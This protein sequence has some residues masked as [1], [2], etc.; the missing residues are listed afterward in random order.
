MQK[1]CILA[2]PVPRAGRYMTKAELIEFNKRTHDELRRS[3]SW[4]HERMGG[5]YQLQCD[6]LG[7]YL[8]T[9]KPARQIK[10]LV[11]EVPAWGRYLTLA[12]TL[13]ARKAGMSCSTGTQVRP[14]AEGGPVLVYKLPDGYNY[15]YRLVAYERRKAGRRSVARV[16]EVGG[17]KRVPCLTRRLPEEGRTLSATERAAVRRLA[18]WLGNGAGLVLPWLDGGL[19]VDSKCM[20][21]YLLVKR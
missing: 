1:L 3:T 15:C 17:C 11:S 13:H 2:A 21:N 10:C 7:R 8:L 16:Q 9:R 20:D 19:L 12:E 14:V 4:V 18:P 5:D 6:G